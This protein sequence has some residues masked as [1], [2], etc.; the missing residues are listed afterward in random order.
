MTEAVPPGAV[1]AA[2]GDGAMAPEA[3]AAAWLIDPLQCLRGPRRHRR[4]RHP[5]D[6]DYPLDGAPA[7]CANSPLDGAPVACANW[8]RRE[9]NI[10]SC[11]AYCAWYRVLCGN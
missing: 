8:N 11:N 7:V 1:V 9:T 6:S 2:A 4:S 3:V 5:R 10:E